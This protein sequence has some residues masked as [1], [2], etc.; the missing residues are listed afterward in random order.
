MLPPFRKEIVIITLFG[1]AKIQ[2]GNST[3]DLDEA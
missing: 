2:V 3:Y 1:H